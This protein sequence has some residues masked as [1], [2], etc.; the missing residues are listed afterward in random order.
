MSYCL[1]SNSHTHTHT[2]YTEHVSHRYTSFHGVSQANSPALIENSNGRNYHPNCLPIYVRL[3]GLLRL[4]APTFC[5]S[6]AL[7]I[8]LFIF[9]FRLL[10][11]IKIPY[12]G[13]CFDARCR[14]RLGLGHVA[15]IFFRLFFCFFFR[16]FVFIFVNFIFL[17]I[18]C[19]LFIRLGLAVFGLLLTEIIL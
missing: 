2:H 7:F 11:L 19:E 10:R 8:F 16:C 9:S 6:F 14:H 12:I 3:F 17:L 4:F 13:C 18:F 5:I 1:I 15:G